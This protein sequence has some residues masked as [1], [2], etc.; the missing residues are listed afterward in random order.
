MTMTWHLF[1]PTRKTPQNAASGAVPGPPAAGSP[2]AADGQRVNQRF[3]SAYFVA[4]AL[5]GP[6]SEPVGTEPPAAGAGPTA[7]GARPPD[8]LDD[9]PPTVNVE[10]SPSGGAKPLSL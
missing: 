3:P 5:T 4:V 6:A 7:E 9:E 10:Y 1:S 2:P 8:P